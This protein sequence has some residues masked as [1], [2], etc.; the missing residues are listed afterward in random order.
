MYPL[1]RQKSLDDPDAQ[2]CSSRALRAGV[3]YAN[4]NEIGSKE[5]D[6]EEAIRNSLAPGLCGYAGDGRRQAGEEPALQNL[7]RCD[8]RREPCGRVQ[9]RP[10]ELGGMTT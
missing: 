2:L 8:R 5:L 3:R 6:P 4:G 9:R 7:P 10:L 1:P